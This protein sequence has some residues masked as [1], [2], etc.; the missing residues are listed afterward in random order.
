MIKMAA[1]HIAVTPIPPQAHCHTL[2]SS[3]WSSGVA[4]MAGRRRASSS[5]H[6]ASALLARASWAIIRPS[7]C[8]QAAR[9]AREGVHTTV[10]QE[11]GSRAHIFRPEQY[12]MMIF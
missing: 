5:A 6:F 7:T 9:W 11:D 3:Q 1:A 8:S 12:M 2:H 4:V 10:Y